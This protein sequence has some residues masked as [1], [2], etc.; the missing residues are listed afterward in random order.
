MRNDLDQVCDVL[1]GQVVEMGERAELMLG[2]ALVALRDGDAAAARH[3][4]D[5]DVEVDRLDGTVQAGVVAAIARHGPVGRDLRLLTAMLRASLHL[6]RMG[7]YAVNVAR[8]A[9]RSLRYPS[10]PDLAAQL[11][12]MGD[13][14]REVGRDAVRA[15]VHGDADLATAVPRKD[16]GV[17]RLNI[18][19]FHRLV[20][21]AAED[22][23]RLEWATR[24][25]LVARLLE[26]YGDHGVD[27]AEQTLFVVTGEQVELSSN[28]PV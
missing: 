8:A 20:R 16:D 27:L 7:D 24:M 18:G 10:D 14:A 3:V 6:E 19:I 22:E 1:L 26:R 17:D 5:E 28:D 12:E 25:I 23:H 15:F 13:L 2:R 9:E 21:L 4:I 11:S